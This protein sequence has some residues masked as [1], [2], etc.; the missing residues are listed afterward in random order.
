MPNPWQ[1]RVWREQGSSGAYADMDADVRPDT[2]PVNGTPATAPYPEG[3]S[4]TAVL[5]WAGSDPQRALVALQAERQRPDP[6]R[7]VV[8]PLE[9]LVGT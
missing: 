4:V 2:T 1:A 3:G 8:A 9:R 5:A 6:R 7:T